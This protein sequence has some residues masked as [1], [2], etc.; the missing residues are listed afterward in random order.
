MKQRLAKLGLVR[1]LLFALQTNWYGR[2]AIPWLI[3]ALKVSA[4]AN[5]TK[6]DAIKPLVSYLA[7]NLHDGK[8]QSFFGGP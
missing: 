3:E 2:E 4:L 7:A 6:D 5:F 1:R 8:L